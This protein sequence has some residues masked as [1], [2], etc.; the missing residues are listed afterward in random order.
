[1]TE[2]AHGTAVRFDHVTVRYAGSDRHAVSDATLDVSAGQFVVIVGPSGCGKSTLLR[3]VNRLIQPQSGHVF[4]DGRD[5]AT[6]DV[7][8]LRRHIGYV[9]QAVGLFAHMTVAQNIAVVP[10]LLGWNPQQTKAR[11]DE[12]LT[13]V[14][15]EPD[16]YQNRYPRE[17]SGGEAQRVGVARALAAR[18]GVLLMDEPFGAVDAIVRASLQDET[19]QIAQMLATTILFVTHDVDEGLKLADRLVIMRDGRIVQEGTPLE[20]LTHPA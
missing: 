9:I 10:S 19:K 16:A 7:T 17:L 11:I 2:S 12:L 6:V 3:T 4:V 20:I 13:L 14:H 8:E 15:L 5:N 1:M 18:P